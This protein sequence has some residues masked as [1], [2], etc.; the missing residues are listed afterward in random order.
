LVGGIP[1]WQLV[2]GWPFPIS[3]VACAI[4]IVKASIAYISST[5]VA[6]LTSPVTI[7]RLIAL[8]VAIVVL[9]SLSSPDGTI[10]EFSRASDI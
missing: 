3:G 10:I 7:D 5:K 2:Q 1:V 8:A 9:R 6:A 4:G